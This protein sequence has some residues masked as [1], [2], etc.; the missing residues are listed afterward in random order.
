MNLTINKKIFLSWVVKSNRGN[1]AHLLFIKIWGQN[2]SM[3]PMRGKWTFVD[4]AQ[5][6]SN[7]QRNQWA[8]LPKG[9]GHFLGH[10]Y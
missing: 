10:T 9:N 1:R 2:V 3:V 7:V 4:Q 6:L 8:A 5:L